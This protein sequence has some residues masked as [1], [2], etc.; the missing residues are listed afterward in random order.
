MKSLKG[1]LWGV[2]KRASKRPSYDVRWSVSDKVFSETFRTK[3][4]AD[5]Y[6]TKLMS[7]ARD[8]EEFDDAGGRPESMSEKKT[9]L[10]WYAFALKYLAMKWPHAA[11]NTR[12]G[13]NESLTSVTIALLNDVPG[14]PGAPVLRQALRN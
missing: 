6:R 7:A 9:E 11:P 5:H 3:A 1:E 4:L 14:R 12:D 13:M 2:R 10:T 8:G